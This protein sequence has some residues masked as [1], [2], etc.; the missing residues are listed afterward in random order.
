MKKKIQGCKLTPEK[1]IYAEKKRMKSFMILS[2]FLAEIKGFVQRKASGRLI[3]FLDLQLY[4]PPRTLQ[5][6]CVEPLTV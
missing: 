6:I 4:S 1:T 5:W 2:S 3:Y